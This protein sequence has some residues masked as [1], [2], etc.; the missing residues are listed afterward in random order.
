MSAWITVAR[1]RRFALR[2]WI[3]RHA[4]RVLP[5]GWIRAHTA[6]W[7]DPPAW[8]DTIV[9]RECAR[10]GRIDGRARC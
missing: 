7:D 2:C 4:W 10:C 8:A 1:P 6:P 5:R 9:L 3:G